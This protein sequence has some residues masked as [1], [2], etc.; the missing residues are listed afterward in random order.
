[1]TLN[2]GPI[3][4]EGGWRRLNVLV[5]RAKWKTVLVTSVRS[6]ELV[7][8]N[9]DNKGAIG[10]KNYIQYAETGYLNE[11]KKA[12]HPLGEKLMTLKIPLGVNWRQEDLKWMLRL[13]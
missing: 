11:S 2:F 10:L 9:P 13:E 7:G 5:T 4:T 12:A 6:S 1:M 8:I 3:N